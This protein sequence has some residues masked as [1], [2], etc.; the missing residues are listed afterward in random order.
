MNFLFLRGRM[1]RHK[2]CRWKTLGE[3]TDMWTHLFAGVVGNS[4]EN[5]GDIVYSN[6]FKLK[7][8][9]ENIDEVWIKKFI[10]YYEGPTITPDVIIARGGFKEYV[11][12]LRKYPKAKVRE[13]INRWMDGGEKLPD[14]VYIMI[15]EE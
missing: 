2:E 10:H 13:I 12:L 8:L 4:D 1:E 5:S 3:C 15:E 14:D 11:P 7:H 6:G 9:T